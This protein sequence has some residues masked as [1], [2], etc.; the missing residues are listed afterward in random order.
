MEGGT[1]YRLRIE[2]GKCTWNM[3]CSTPAGEGHRMCPR[4][5][6]MR[7]AR[8][9]TGRPHGRV[10]AP[11][12]FNGMTKTVKEWAAWLG[13]STDRM[14]TR[15]KR[16]PLELALTAAPQP[17]RKLGRPACLPPDKELEAPVPGCQRC[18]LRGE[19]VC[20][21]PSA[22]WFTEFRVDRGEATMDLRGGRKGVGGHR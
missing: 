10:A 5:A 9:R 6:E 20:L 15:L 11:I 22:A 12:T 18:G 2:Q 13:L 8:R 14:Y 3:S 19:H 7:R 1:T 21:P 17:R 4:H 16:Y